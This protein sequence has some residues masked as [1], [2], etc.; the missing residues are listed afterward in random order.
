VAT[1]PVSVERNAGL[2][3]AA[4]KPVSLRRVV[5]VPD[6]GATAAVTV[7]LDAGPAAG[8]AIA[9]RAAR[10]FISPPR[11]NPALSAHLTTVDPAARHT[12]SAFLIALWRSGREH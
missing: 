11:A 12:A 9:V 1:G 10:F 3:A 5:S 4:A 7:R 2:P 8:A 6:F